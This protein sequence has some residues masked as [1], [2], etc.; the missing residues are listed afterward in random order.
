MITYLIQLRNLNKSQFLTGSLFS[1]NIEKQSL[2]LEL[3]LFVLFIKIE[4]QLMS[5]I[6]PQAFLFNKLFKCY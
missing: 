1:V 4:I 2:K 5:Y 3:I 6:S